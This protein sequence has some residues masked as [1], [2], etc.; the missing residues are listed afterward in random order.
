VTHLETGVYQISVSLTQAGEWKASVTTS[1]TYQ[2]AKPRT[3]NVLA[4]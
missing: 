1:G 4:N 2:A 3:I